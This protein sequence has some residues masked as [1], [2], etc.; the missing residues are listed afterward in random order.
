[1]ICA[2]IRSF[3]GARVTIDLY[4]QPLQAV[5]ADYTSFV[6]ILNADGEMIA[7]DDHLVGGIYYPTHL[8][9]PGEL[10]KDSHTLALGSDLGRAPYSIVTGLYHMAPDL[11]HLG[12]PEQIGLV[13][14]QRPADPL[15][16]NL[17]NPLN[18]TF[19]DQIALNGYEMTTERSLAPV[20]VLLAGSAHARHRLHCICPRVGS[21]GRIVAQS[22]QQPGSGEAPTSTWTRGYTLTD[23]V[24][25]GIPG[26][27]PA[28]KYQIEVGLYDANN[29]T[30]LPIYDGKGRLIGDAVPLNELDWPPKS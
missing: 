24:E 12:R 7:Q 27:V 4:W 10:L 23:N 13:G 17:S 28:G 6:H 30:R 14:R 22:D 26:S 19:D 20:A 2:L 11:Q 21:A 1:M 16:Q 9:R 29:L 15:P 5:D 25:I 8:W 3:D 18:Y